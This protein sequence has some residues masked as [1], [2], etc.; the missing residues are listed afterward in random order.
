M[1]ARYGDDEI[2]SA[3]ADHDDLLALLERYDATVSVG[4]TKLGAGVRAFQRRMNRGEGW[5]T[6][7][8]WVLRVD[9]TETDFSF[10]TAIAGKPKP[11]SAEFTDACR[12]AVAGDI[13]AAKA[14]H[15]AEHADAEGR[16]AC[17]ISGLPLS[18]K[19]AHL[20]HAEPSFGHLVVV[21]R[22]ESGWE[23]TIPD[24]ILT[25]PDDNQMTTT[26]VDDQVAEAF[27]KFHE[28]RA[29]LRVI[30]AKENMSRA[31]GQRNPGA[32]TI[33]I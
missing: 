7:G 32:T 18:E 3:R 27:R 30:S 11:Q 29:T 25:K 1:L 17:A 26:F 28:A 15:F 9:G 22:A 16:V 4:Q 13:K 14:R 31:A 23:T 33:R 10:P 12:A 19:D 8:F 21:F 24:G 5:Q 2:I 20:D 6:A